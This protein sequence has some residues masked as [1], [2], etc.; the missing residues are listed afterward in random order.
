[1]DV[2]KHNF[3][4]IVQPT[5]SFQVYVNKVNTYSYK[6]T[7]LNILRKLNFST[8]GLGISTLILKNVR[9]R[10]DEILCFSNNKKDKL[11]QKIVIMEDL[12]SIAPLDG[13]VGSK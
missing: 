13:S 10:S 8:E 6:V 1:M 12:T 5:F 4:E 7:T 9:K 11:Y 3:I 2:T